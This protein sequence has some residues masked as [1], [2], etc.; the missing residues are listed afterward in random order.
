VAGLSI[1][2][3]IEVSVAYVSPVD[4]ERH[5]SSLQMSV[6]PGGRPLRAGDALQVLASNTKE[7][8]TRQV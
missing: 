6:S 7:D 8:K 2:H 5:A 4:G 1:K 3:K